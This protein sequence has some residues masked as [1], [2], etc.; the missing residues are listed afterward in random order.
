[1]DLD[2]LAKAIV[3]LKK[4]DSDDNILC[5]F[6]K[7]RDVRSLSHEDLILQTI[8]Y[9]A[10][11]GPLSDEGAALQFAIFTLIKPNKD[12]ILLALVPY[13]TTDDR[14]VK[15]IVQGIAISELETGYAQQTP[16][17]GQYT[18]LLHR[19]R[20][21]P[22]PALLEY[23][24]KRDPSE[25]LSATIELRNNGP[26]E[27]EHDYLAAATV[28]REWAY[29]RQRGL[30]PDVRRAVAEL[31]AMALDHHWTARAFVAACMWKHGELR[32]PPLVERLRK[33][34]HPLV[35]KIAEQIPPYVASS[36]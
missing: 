4:D 14:T 27:H 30:E 23:M 35:K 22:P 31:Q 8:Y 28:V 29:R 33:D 34:E 5:A 12:V 7:L 19:M 15:R 10:H 32:V 20:D 16:F 17:F 3:Q 18:S 1:M 6:R 11:H 13:L 21:N 24:Y 2:D 36:R 9:L 26:P 25:A